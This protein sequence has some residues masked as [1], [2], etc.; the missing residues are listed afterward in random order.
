MVDV[1]VADG[2]TIAVR[3]HGNP[4][5]PRLV[6]SHGCGLAADLYYPYW[7]LLADRFD[8]CIF[9]LR[10]HGWNPAVPTESF[11]IP[12]L[13]EDNQAVIESIS[14]CWGDK[15][16]YG[17]FHSISTI[18]GLAHQ[19]KRSDFA[20][21]MLF[22][23][24]LESIGT[25][26]RS[27]DEA[28]RLQ[29]KRARRRQGHF[30]SPDELAELLGQASIYSYMR[31]EVRRLLAETTLKPAEG[32]GYEF[33]CPPEQEAQLYEWYFGFSMRILYQ[34][35]S[36]DIPLKVVGADP[37]SGYAFMPSFDLSALAKFN[38]DFLPGKTHFL[39]LEA[40][41][42]CAELT[43]EFLESHVLA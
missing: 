38:Y 13:V 8:V 10:S 9:D 23:P 31:P 33:R 17:V 42:E 14:S 34:I 4:D 32:G 26:E 39:Q 28:C 24:A 15:P 6:L 29:A 25:G 1:N 27:L 35:D 16:C 30:D 11:N 18:I 3:R 41:E 37:L 22:D 21:L 12:T 7:S 2:A 5:G 20:A 43:V 36:F 40:P 19:L